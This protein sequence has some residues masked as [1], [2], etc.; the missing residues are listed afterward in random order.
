MQACCPNADDVYWADS[1]ARRN[2][3]I[4]EVLMGSRADEGLDWPLADEAAGE[5]FTSP[6]RGA[7]FLT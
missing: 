5:A 7:A 6:G 4:L 1:T 3:P 2:T